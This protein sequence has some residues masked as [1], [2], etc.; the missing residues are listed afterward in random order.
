MGKFGDLIKEARI[1]REL[2][3]KDVQMET[4]IDYT[5]L[6]RLEKGERLPSKEQVYH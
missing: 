4:G 3:Q 1:E 5:L 2:D 6:S